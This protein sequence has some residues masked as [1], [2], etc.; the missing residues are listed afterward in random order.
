MRVAV[1]H[2]DVGA[3]AA[4]D[5][6]DTLV[7]ADAVAAALRALGHDPTLVPFRLAL[8]DLGRALKASRADVVFNLVETVFGED[9][10]A[11][12]APTVFEAL[13]MPYT[14]SA[15][16]PIALAADKPLSKRVLHAAGL[17]TPPWSEGPRWQGLEE[18]RLYI[19]KSATEDASLGLDDGALVRGRGA[20][21]AR[22]L[23]SAERHGGRWFAEGYVEGREFNVAILETESGLGALPIPE[24]R[25]EDWPEA[26]P[27]IV[28]YRAKW[29]EGSED[30]R[31]TV[32]AF[33]LERGEPYLARTLADLALQAAR[34]FG[35]R[36]YTRVDFRMDRDGRPFILE[37]NPNPCLAP[38]AGFAAAAKEA[39]F[40]YQAL[41][42]SI[43]SAAAAA[44]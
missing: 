13:S 20:A 30:A 23:Q 43:L 40:T 25:F 11:A 9:S 32:R 42:G 4:P 39:G 18:D 28:G 7:T 10:L 33:G 27:R 12:M 16:A 35:T 3:D 29:H 41:I 24:M 31:K 14:G 19:V 34:L 21:I 17:P 38:D 6:L 1:V 22:A 5:D 44:R 15:A 26:K 36:G 2:S 8:D 37:I